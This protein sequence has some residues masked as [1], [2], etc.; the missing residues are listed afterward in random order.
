M[1]NLIDRQ[2]VIVALRNIWNALWEI[3]VPSPTVPEYI[4]HHEQVQGIMKMVRDMIDTFPYA[5]SQR[6]SVQD[7]PDMNVGDMISRQ[8]AIKAVARAIWHYPKHS[9]LNNYHFAYELA[10][11]ALKRLPSAEPEPLTDKEQRIFLAAMGR[12]EKV[13]K[14][15]DDECR[16]CREPYENSLVRTCHEIIRKVR[17]ALWT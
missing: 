7:V 5:E 3:D 12:E 17:G 2:D 15:V 9:L 4:E 16:T 13:C 10:E 1:S 14:E 8:D 6:E 11:D